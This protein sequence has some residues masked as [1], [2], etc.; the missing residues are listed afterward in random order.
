M[1][2]VCQLVPLWECEQRL[3]MSKLSGRSELWI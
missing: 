2:T 3:Q 1:W